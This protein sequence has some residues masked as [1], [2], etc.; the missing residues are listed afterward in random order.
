MPDALA[1]QGLLPSAVDPGACNNSSPN[2]CV[3]VTVDP[4]LKQF[5]ALLPPTNGA[6]NGDGTGDLIT[7]NKSSTTENLGTLRIDHN[8]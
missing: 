6:D 2:G 5:L 7:A 4:R 3:A 8:F 1:H